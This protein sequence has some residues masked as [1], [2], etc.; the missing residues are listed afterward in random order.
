LQLGNLLRLMVHKN[1]TTTLNS[2]LVG[3]IAAIEVF[4]AQ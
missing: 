3:K 1:M 2:E 4:V